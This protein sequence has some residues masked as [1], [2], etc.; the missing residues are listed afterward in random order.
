MCHAQR[1]VAFIPGTGP[2]L[3]WHKCQYLHGEWSQQLKGVG[4]WMGA[5]G[6]GAGQGY[7]PFLSSGSG[8]E[9]FFRGQPESAHWVSGSLSFPPWFLSYSCSN[10]LLLMMPFQE[11]HSFWQGS[12]LAF[13]K[14]IWHQLNE[15]E[16]AIFTIFWFPLSFLFIFFIPSNLSALWQTVWSASSP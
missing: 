8:S 16:K 11:C 10:F 7:N 5:G 3:G 4:E 14:A 15:D 2:V 6:G 9:D 12:S 1:G 13:Q